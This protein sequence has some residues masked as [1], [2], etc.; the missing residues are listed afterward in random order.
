MPGLPLSNPRW[1]KFCQCYVQ[2]ETAGNAAGSYRAAG[3]PS[4]WVGNNATKL[5]AKPVVRA[6]IAELQRDIMNM[7]E[8]ALKTATERLAL[9]SE[10]VLGE[11]AN[12]GFANLFDY[13]RQKPEGEW[14]IDFSALERD[15]GAGLVE[16]HMT[17]TAE[18]DR[19][20]RNVKIKMGGKV[21]ALGLLGKHL[22]LFVDRKDHDHDS[23]RR[24]SIDEIKREV[25]DIDRK[26]GD[27]GGG[28]AAP[29][30]VADQ[31]E[32]LLPARIG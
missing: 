30:D 6:R 20:K 5:L 1:E 19:R 8:T 25:A 32:A 26:L 21:V 31:T 9:R 22:G 24:V 29:A 23:V 27:A 4:P 2:G 16:F 10:A 12:V 3:F 18:G 13:V 17:E 11:L 14:V 7:E 15:K 28:A